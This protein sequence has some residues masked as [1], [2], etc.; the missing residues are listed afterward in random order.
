LVT[1]SLMP[2]MSLQITGR[3]WKNASCITSGEFSHQ[4]EGTTTQSI[5]AIKLESSALS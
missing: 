3:P 1:F 4:I 2:P 5:F